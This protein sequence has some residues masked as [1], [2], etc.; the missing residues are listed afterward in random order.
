MRS[1]V[2]RTIYK[3]ATVMMITMTTTTTHDHEYDDK[4][5]NYEVI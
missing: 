5:K 1:N 4:E 2:V 3:N